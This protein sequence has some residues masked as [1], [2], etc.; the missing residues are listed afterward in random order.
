MN[1]LSLLEIHTSHPDF[2]AVI[3]EGS[4]INDLSKYCGKKRSLKEKKR[5][6]NSTLCAFQISFPLKEVQD[7]DKRLQEQNIIPLN[8][9]PPVLFDFV[10]K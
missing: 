6:L 8:L 2:K 4:E 10:S 3:Q 9:A 1:L 7:T 5:E